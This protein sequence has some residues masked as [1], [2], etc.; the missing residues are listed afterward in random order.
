MSDTLAAAGL[1]HQVL[2][3]GFIRIGSGRPFAGPVVCLG[4]ESSTEPGLSIRAIDSAIRPGNI[5]V[6]G[7]GDGCSAALVG[8]NMITSWKRLGAAVIVVNGFVRDVDSFDGLP[9]LIHGTTPVNCRGLWRFVSTDAPIILPGQIAPIR[10]KPG[11]W[12]HSDRD[13]TVVLP[14]AKLI[15][16]IEDAE[17]VGRIERNMRA[18][19][20]AG[21]DRQNVYERHDRFGHVRRAD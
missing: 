6:V 8:G 2:A 17:Q 18:L 7:P 15:S 13:G 10:I 11:D 3:S 9:A 5:V 12:L 16:L 19:I 1:P 14:A 21:E 4:G 20:E